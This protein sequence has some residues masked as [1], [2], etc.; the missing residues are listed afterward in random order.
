MHRTPQLRWSFVL[1][2][3]NF[4]NLL[5][6]V[7]ESEFSKSQHVSFEMIKK[8]FENG[9][10]LHISKRQGQRKTIFSGLGASISLVL[11]PTFP[12]HRSPLLHFET[13]K[14]K[15]EKMSKW[16][17]K[18]THLKRTFRHAQLH[19]RA[20]IKNDTIFS[21]RFRVPKC[22]TSCVSY[23]K[24][25]NYENKKDHQTIRMEPTHRLLR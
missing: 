7:T 11:S 4:E 22:R 15:L 12:Q 6:T 24:S 8:S 1:R 23:M 3:L 10:F 19:C 13:L 2:C 16:W 9:T 21:L 20:V 5:K 18:K 14:S 17:P 25:V